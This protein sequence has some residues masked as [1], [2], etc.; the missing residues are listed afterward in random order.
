MNCAVQTDFECNQ[1]IINSQVSSTYPEHL[2]YINKSIGPNTNIAN[3]AT[4]GHRIVTDIADVV[5]VVNSPVKS[6]A[7]LCGCKNYDTPFTVTKNSSQDYRFDNS[8]NRNK[9]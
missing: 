7:G 5:G 6:Y 9:N 1:Y 8:L 2:S 4:M 3:K